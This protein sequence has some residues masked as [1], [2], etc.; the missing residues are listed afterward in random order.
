MY[1]RRLSR[2]G[3]GLRRLIDNVVVCKAATPFFI[4]EY[5]GFAIEK[6]SGLTVYIRQKNYPLM[7]ECYMAL[8]WYKAIE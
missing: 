5:T 6:H 1:K 8:D 2:T 4:Q 3:K 7:N